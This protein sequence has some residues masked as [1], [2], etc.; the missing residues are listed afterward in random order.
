MVFKINVKDTLGFGGS[1]NQILP[2]STSPGVI[3]PLVELLSQ[4]F[5]LVQN[6]DSKFLLN[7]NHD[8][9]VYRRFIRSGG[10]KKHAVLLIR[11]PFAV[12]PKQFQSE[13]L[14]KYGLVLGPGFARDSGINALNLPCPYIYSTNPNV[15]TLNEVAGNN[16]SEVADKFC[17]PDFSQWKKREICISMIASNKVS[18]TSHSNYRLR[19]SIAKNFEKD[20]VI[21]GDLWRTSLGSRIKH[22]LQVASFNLKSGFFPNPVSLYGNLLRRYPYAQGEVENKHEVLKASKFSLIIENDV[23]FCTEKIIDCMINGAIPVYFGPNPT[24]FGIPKN[25]Y[26]DLYNFIHQRHSFIEK[27][28][29]TYCQNLLKNAH[30]FLN[31]TDFT[32]NWLANRVYSKLNSAIKSYFYK[33]TNG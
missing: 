14:N 28:D 25:S 21:Y 7:V 29:V 22:R 23:F 4:D 32:D 19:R 24:D 11:E 9:K 20:I 31:S 3:A 27:Q 16:F 18:P 5:L 30:C 15:V 13:V 10:E 2:D 33:N 6:Q 17:P 12:Y 1:A 26:I 8:E